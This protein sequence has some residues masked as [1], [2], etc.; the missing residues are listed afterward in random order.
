[1]TVAVEAVPIENHQWVWS[2]GGPGLWEEVR[3]QALARL[4]EMAYGTGRHIVESEVIERPRVGL[5]WVEE[6]QDEDGD[7]TGAFYAIGSRE[8]PVWDGEPE[9]WHA[10][11]ATTAYPGAPPA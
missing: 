10:V 2:G 8:V 11:W 3:K 9:M 5:V 7:P 4:H 6:G 1:M